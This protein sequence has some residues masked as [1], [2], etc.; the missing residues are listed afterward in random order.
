MIFG[1]VY[2]ALIALLLVA[3]IISIII[4]AIM[5]NRAKTWQNKFNDAE[6][7][8]NERVNKINDAHQK[9][10]EDWRAKI[11]IVE[12]E[13]EAERNNIKIQYRDLKHETQKIIKQPIYS[14]CLLD[15][16][17][18]SIAEAARVAANTRKSI[19]TMP[20]P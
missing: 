2:K 1:N 5:M 19:D 20:E 13:L 10:I 17:G 12:N 6:Q 15:D 16:A 14:D 8:C 11:F 3:L 9:A 4:S 7:L 18:M